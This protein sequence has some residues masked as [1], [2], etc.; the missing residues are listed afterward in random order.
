[1]QQSGSL[2]PT[3]GFLEV[4]PQQSLEKRDKDKFVISDDTIHLAT[5]L[6]KARHHNV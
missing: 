3:F 1:M 6:I 5:I 2:K 4:K